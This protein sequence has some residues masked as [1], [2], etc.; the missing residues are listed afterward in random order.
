VSNNFAIW[1]TLIWHMRLP[2]C[3]CICDSL[4]YIISQH[5]FCT[6]LFYQFFLL[7]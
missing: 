1:E 4:Y 5:N 6:V 3:I 7:C 2:N